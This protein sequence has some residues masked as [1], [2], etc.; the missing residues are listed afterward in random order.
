MK[1]LFLTFISVFT[2]LYSQAQC[3]ADFSYMQNGPTTIFTDL[4]TMQSTN[5]SVTWD[6][7][8]GDGNTSTQQNPV[9]T[10]SNGIYSPCL[11]VT[12]FDSTIINYCTSIYCYSL[13]IGNGLP[14]SWDC[15][16]ATGCYDPGTGN[17]Q[18]T[19][20]SAC[21]VACA[22]TPSWDCNPN[23]LGCY[24]PGTGLG[25]YT[26]LASCQSNCGNVTDS[27]AC[28]VGVAPGITTCVGP[29]IYTMGQANVIAVYST[30]AACIADSCN[31]M[32][33]LASWDCDPVNGCYDPGTG[34]G[35]YT[36]LSACQSVCSGVTASLDCSPN[37]LGCYD[38][39]TGNGQYTTLVACQSNCSSGTSNYCDSM[40]ASG[41][42]SQIIMEVNNI[43][44]F[45]DYWVT[46]GNNGTILGEDSMSTNHNVF[47]YNPS[48]GLPFDTIVTCIT[49]SLPQLT[50][51]CCVTWIWNG[52]FWSKSDGV[53]SIEEINYT[54]KRLIK[55]VDILGRKTFPKSNE[56]LFFIYDD[57]SIE[58]RYMIE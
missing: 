45:I 2:I 10:Y 4:S 30:M 5:Y 36:S 37:V 48:T 29:G 26:T 35:Q 32:P 54:D 20:L 23:M 55:I 58:R 39:G 44:T 19:T 8:F 33:P 57:G 18:Y 9:H 41:S 11:T 27:F 22:T 56:T 15:T 28:M 16:P 6:W 38:P 17:G 1:K 21:Q 46:T 40:T 3:Q 7:D 51:T 24:D 34:N 43:N 47:N 50:F 42:Q 49:V 12:F 25:Q 14:V 52:T 31:V 13:L 53:T